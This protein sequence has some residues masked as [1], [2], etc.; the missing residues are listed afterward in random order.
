MDT[1]HDVTLTT[2][3]QIDEE[4]VAKYNLESEMYDYYK[5]EIPREV[6]NK[7]LAQVPTIYKDVFE[8]A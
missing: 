5:D 4:E 8:D 2:E 1:S 7:G 3:G 6:I